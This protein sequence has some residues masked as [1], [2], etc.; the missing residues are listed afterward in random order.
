VL[1]TSTGEYTS[2]YGRWT[3]PMLYGKTAAHSVAGKFNKRW[4]VTYYKAVPVEVK[5]K[6]AA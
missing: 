2:G 3:T 4:G 1:N 6:E 5:L